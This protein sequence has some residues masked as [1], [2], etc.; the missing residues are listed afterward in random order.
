VAG[1]QFERCPGDL[2]GRAVPLEK[3]TLLYTLF[4]VNAVFRYITGAFANANR[5]IP[6]PQIPSPVSVECCLHTACIHL[7]T[8]SPIK[9]KMCALTQFNLLLPLLIIELV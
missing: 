3:G 6:Y 2:A 7:G 8:T 4:A 1:G 5:P 9:L